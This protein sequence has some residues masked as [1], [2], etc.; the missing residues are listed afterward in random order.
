M[1]HLWLF[2]RYLCLLYNM[3]R[4]A[5]SE[6]VAISYLFP[7]LPIESIRS[8]ILVN[9]TCSKTIKNNEKYIYQLPFH[10][11]NERGKIGL[12]AASANKL[13]I[14]RALNI[15]SKYT[16][17][18]ITIAFSLKSW[19]IIKIGVENDWEFTTFEFATI[20]VNTRGTNLYEVCKKKTNI[21]IMEDIQNTC[22]T[23]VTENHPDEKT[24]LDISP[25]S[26]PLQVNHFIYLAMS[27]HCSTNKMIHGFY[28]RNQVFQKSDIVK[29]SNRS[30]YVKLTS[31]FDGYLRFAVNRSC[32]LSL[33]V[34]DA[35]MNYDPDVIIPVISA[36]FSPIRLCMT[37][38]CDQ[39]NDDFELT[40]TCVLMT[41]KLRME[42]IRVPILWGD[43]MCMSGFAG[44]VSSR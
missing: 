18:I 15:T 21:I 39:E 29:I 40:G 16:S 30:Y 19:D 41:N 35:S 42:I 32:K 43:N 22:E 26:C 33:S 17:K 20:L 28:Q 9:L 44:S 7:Y 5:L 36:G 14:I 6:W 11:D 13:D 24:W 38:D 12:L 8:L 25:P 27:H 31:A 34:N 3:I 4:E 23:V 1:I 10:T 37:F 2:K